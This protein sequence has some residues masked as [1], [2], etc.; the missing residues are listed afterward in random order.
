MFCA[1]ATLVMQ[2]L[3]ISAV[4][5]LPAENTDR[6]ILNIRVGGRAIVV[7]AAAFFFSRML[8]VALVVGADPLATA[9]LE[10]R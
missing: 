8:T 1:V 3:L 5:R 10:C 6:N 4:F 2:L 9:A 7:R